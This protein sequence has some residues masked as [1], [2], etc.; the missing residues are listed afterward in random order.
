MNTSPSSYIRKPLARKR[1]GIALGVSAAAL[2]LLAAASVWTGAVPIPP[3]ELWGA[4]W[5]PN[6]AEKASQILWNVRLPRIAAAI[7]S[8]AGLAVAGALL[9]AVLNNA[10]ASPGVIG[11]NAGSGL[12]VLLLAAFA[13]GLAVYTPV[14]A[15]IGAL[16][17][18]GLV[19]GIARR[20][21]ASR[22][23]LVLSGV[24]VSSILSALSDAVL[25]LRPETQINRTA[26][27]IGSFSAVAPG[28]LGFAA[29]CTAIGLLIA[30]AVSYDL[31][32]L[33]LGD[34]LSRSLGLRAGLCRALAVG[35]AAL[36]AGSAVSIAGLLGFVGLIVPH[37][38]RA[39]GGEDQRVLLPLCALMGAAFT[40]GCDLLAR[41]L[42]AP[43][44]LPVGILLS[45]LGGPFFLY[46]LVRRKRGRFHA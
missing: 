2:V 41:I 10:L 38:A 37:A 3:G 6:A 26:F 1:A 25:T 30:F 34:E 22:M 9:Q 18:A 27:L 4:L 23:T 36:L 16:A 40:L 43:F 21:G 33:S 15:F 46:L 28:S 14:A 11:V 7:F 20:T 5:L 29:T 12:A 13:P 32:V 45:L 17:A 44:E 39:L 8:G 19:Y 35:A 31:N 42:F 24:A